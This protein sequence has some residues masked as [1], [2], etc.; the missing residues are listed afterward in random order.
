V[1]TG[2]GSDEVFPGHVFVQPGRGGLGP[3][4]SGGPGPHEPRR[5][6][7]N[8]SVVS[9]LGFVPMPEHAGL[10]SPG[11]QKRIRR[12]FDR[13]HWRRLDSTSALER[14]R[15]RIDRTQTDGRPAARKIQ[16][17]WIKSILAPYLLMI[18]GDRA[19]MGHSIEGRAPVLD[20]VL[21]EAARRIPDRFRIRDGVEKNTRCVRR[22]R[23]GSRAGSTRAESGRTPH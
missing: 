4:I 19:E 18:L 22:S 17:A 2:E 14:L 23:T 13:R 6:P 8:N 21:F 5:P 20:H 15:A 11:T 10:L 7:D 16:Y 3:Q 12:L 9:S 1:L